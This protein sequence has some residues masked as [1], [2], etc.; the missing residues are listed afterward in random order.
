MSNLISFD[1]FAKGKTTTSNTAGNCVIYTRVS[2]KEQADNNMSL[3][4]QRKYCETFAQKNG[5]PI[6]GHYGGTYES[7][8]TDE[9]NQFNKMLATVK[10]SNQKISY[11][12]V[13]SVDRFSRSG[14]NAIYI[15]EPLKKQGIS[16]VSVTQP[17]DSTTASGSLQQN[18]QFIFSE[19][20]NQL[21]REKCVTG[22]RESLLRGEWC[23]RL[24]LGYDIIRTN[25]VRKIVV[26]QKGK[27]LKKA[28]VWKAEH[29]Y[30]SERI[31]EELS[32]L[33]LKLC[34]QRIP[35]ILR[36]PFY[37]GLISH[38]LLEG[39]VV[40]GKHEKVVSRELFLKANT[41]LNKKTNGY[42][43][44]LE[45]EA[46]PLKRFMKCD[47]CGSYLRGYIAKKRALYYYKCNTP[48][49]KNNQSAT[50][51]NAAFSRIISRFSLIATD[52]EKD[53]IKQQIIAL[54]NQSKEDQHSA[55]ETAESQ[56]REIVKKLDRIEERFMNEEISKEL[57][58]KYTL[59]L[60]EER[61]QIQQVLTRSENPVSNM[62]RKIDYMIEMAGKLGVYWGS[63]N[64][65]VKQ[66]LQFMVFPEGISYNRKQA[67]VEQIRSMGYSSGS[68]AGR[69][70]SG[71]KKAAYQS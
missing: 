45:N 4:T 32:K 54:Y 10:K 59:K 18:I 36:N 5:Y 8:K 63:A 46:L 37:C 34:H 69:R 3:D 49:C 6:L 48:G 55:R 11:I 67:S 16:I 35:E 43:I 23:T 30:S 9:R 64:Y 42:K 24:P 52:S 50:K 31:R 20:D 62:E 41:A 51:L 21:R 13:Y 2:T 25:G 58:D 40:E 68:C 38:N 39:K 60:K 14:A 56:L 57:Y 65:V 47:A 7:A 61:T 17:T 44:S 19:Y 26:N 33:G 71:M 53:L 1:S 15:A 66:K 70:T 12:V 29:G 27:L 22:T 28:F